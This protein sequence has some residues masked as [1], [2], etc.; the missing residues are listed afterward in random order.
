MAQAEVSETCRISRK[1][2]TD[3]TQ[4]TTK[5]VNGGSKVKAID[6]HQSECK[7]KARTFSSLSLSLSLYHLCPC[8]WTFSLLLLP[9]L[10]R[11]TALLSIHSVFLFCLVL[12]LCIWSRLILF[13][14]HLFFASLLCKALLFPSDLIRVH[15]S[16]LSLSHTSYWMLEWHLK[17]VH[18][19]KERRGAERKWKRI[20]H[21]MQ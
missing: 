4:V 6:W 12:C 21:Q 3:E 7:L 9:Y 10:L 5:A 18:R 11:L 20:L 19:R 15:L 16:P 1:K 13:S 2:V 17:N 8:L 14:M